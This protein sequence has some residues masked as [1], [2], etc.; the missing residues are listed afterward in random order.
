[1]SLTSHLSHSLMMISH[2]LINVHWSKIVMIAIHD[3]FVESTE[4]SSPKGFCKEI[5]NH[6]LVWAIF[7]DNVSAFLYVR[8]KEVSNIHVSCLLAA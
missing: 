4:F 5:T 8:H 1:M 7:D 6:G 2:Q 3:D